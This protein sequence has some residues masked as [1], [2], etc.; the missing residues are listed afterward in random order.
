M[1]WQKVKRE[2]SYNVLFT[3]VTNRVVGICIH[4]IFKVVHSHNVLWNLI[5]VNETIFINPFLMQFWLFSRRPWRTLWCSSLPLLWTENF[6]SIIPRP[7]CSVKVLSVP[8]RSWLESQGM[9]LKYGWRSV[10]T[11]WFNSVYICQFSQNSFFPK[12]YSIVVRACLPQHES[13][14]WH[15]SVFKIINYFLRHMMRN[16]EIVITRFWTHFLVRLIM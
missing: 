4:V 9:S 5:C 8:C 16:S 1:G 11:K 14:K 6:Y 10:S 2:F 7:C 12:T 15:R 13:R 3:K